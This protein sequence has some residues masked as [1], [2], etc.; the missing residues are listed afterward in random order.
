MVAVIPL[1]YGVD[2][3]VQLDMVEVALERG[4]DKQH[5]EL[6]VTTTNTNNYNN[7]SW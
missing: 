4:E 3:V 2:A 1:L 5:K 7:K 6:V